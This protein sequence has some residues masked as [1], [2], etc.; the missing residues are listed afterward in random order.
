MIIEFPTAEEEE[1]SRRFQVNKNYLLSLRLHLERDY[2]CGMREAS[3]NLV[4]ELRQQ[5]G[6]RRIQGRSRV[7]EESCRAALSLSWTGLIQLELASWTEVGFNLPYTNAWAPVHGYYAV[8]GA[9]RAW[10]IAQGQPTDS[11]GATLKTISSEVQSR[12]L[13]PSPWDVVCTGC[14]HDGS[15]VFRNVPPGAVPAAAAILLQAPC[16]ETFW[17]RY[18]K[19][20][21]TTRRHVLEER[22]GEWKQRSNRKRTMLR[23]KRVIAQSVPPTTLFDFLWRLRVRSNYQGVEAYLMTSV[24]NSWHREFH[25]SIR[26]ITHLTSFMFDCWTAQKMGRDKY[27]DA[28]D[29]FMKYRGHSLEPV[30]FLTDRRDC[31]R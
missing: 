19:M 3:I 24:A 30:R 17:P 2:G 6:F 18:L 5:T 29:K 10:L 22:Y 7:D 8:Y 31:L 16:H 27:L 23:E 21:E 4:E 9:A 13:Y 28:I 1:R 25:E 20:L 15:H 12:H 26:L 14:C 11:H